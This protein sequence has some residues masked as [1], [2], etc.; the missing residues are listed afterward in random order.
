VQEL[1]QEVE[2]LERA[3]A[4][5]LRIQTC[6]FLCVFVVLVVGWMCWVSVCVFGGGGVKS[7]RSTPVPWLEDSLTTTTNTNHN[8]KHT[9]PPTIQNPQS[10]TPQAA[11]PRADGEAG[12]GRPGVAGVLDGAPRAAAAAG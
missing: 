12:A 7:R 2:K 6:V 5:A 4:L 10:Q 1:A 11:V 8:D 9:H 3:G